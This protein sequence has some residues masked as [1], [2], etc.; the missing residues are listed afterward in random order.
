MSE[1]L[2]RTV[3]VAA[4]LLVVAMVAVAWLVPGSTGAAQR[5]EARTT[6]GPCAFVVGPARAYCQPPDS[7]RARAHAPAADSTVPI[8]ST[9]VPWAGLAVAAGGLAVAAAG[10]RSR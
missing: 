2:R 7:D 3:Y 8:R 4:G 5:H 9:P 6:A 1:I 10:R